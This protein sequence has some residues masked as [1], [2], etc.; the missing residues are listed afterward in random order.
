MSIEVKSVG[1]VLHI[2]YTI[3]D[4]EELCEIDRFFGAFH[5]LLETSQTATD[6]PPEP[7]TYAEIMAAS[8]DKL[9]LFMQRINGRFDEAR[10]TAEGGAQ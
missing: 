7:S 1:K 2:P 4:K 3:E 9:N 8:V 6:T 10:A 5:E